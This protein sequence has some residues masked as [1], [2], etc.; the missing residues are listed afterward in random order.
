M[1]QRFTIG[2][3][4][5]LGGTLEPPA[6]VDHKAFAA[7]VLAAAA[8]EHGRN[9]K[10]RRLVIADGYQCFFDRAASGLMELK[11]W[12]DVPRDVIR[13]RRMQSKPCPPV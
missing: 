6:S 5:R 1:N 8:S 13:A 3:V 7:A 2:Q 10:S 4:R 9:G 11:L 12:L